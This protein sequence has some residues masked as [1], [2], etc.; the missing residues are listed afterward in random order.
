[1]RKNGWREVQWQN[2]RWENDYIG[3]W[4]QKEGHLWRGGNGLTP[5]PKELATVED[6]S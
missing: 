3:G 1:M 5:E 4:V 6:Y 2:G